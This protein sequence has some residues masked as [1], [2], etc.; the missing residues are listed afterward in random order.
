MKILF[1]CAGYLPDNIGGVEL[2]VHNVAAELK[3]QGHDV[4]VFAR[5]YAPGREEFALDRFVYETVPV[6]KMNYKFSDC[7][8]LEKIYTNPE[9][10]RIFRGVFQEFQPDL[11]HIHHLSC[12][13]T[14]IVHDHQG[15]R[16]CPWP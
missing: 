11:V 10:A 12:L 3:K 13:T 2:H 9:I 6:A 14:D 7:D 4:L 8:S 15:S 5:D 1:V 16:T